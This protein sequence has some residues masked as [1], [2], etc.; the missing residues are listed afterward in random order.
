[1]RIRSIAASIAAASVI[2]GSAIALGSSS[3]ADAATVSAKSRVC[4]AAKTWAHHRTTANLNAL[5]TDSE[6][7][8]WSP[9]GADVVVFY[10]DVR[11]GDTRDRTS[12]L[13]D[14][15]SDGCH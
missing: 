14:I 1:M 10:T 2:S 9:L 4:T 6:S 11:G 15:A 5:M 12:D 8:A 3:H 7:V 13:Q